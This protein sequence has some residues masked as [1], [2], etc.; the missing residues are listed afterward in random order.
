MFTISKNAEAK[1]L[2]LA[3]TLKEN[4][5]GYYALQFNFSQ[6]QEHNRS[7]YQIK[8]AIN[9]IYDL[10]KDVEGG[11][12]ICQDCDMFFLYKGTNKAL[13]EKTIFQLRYLFADDPLAYKPGELENELFC[14]VYDLEFHCHD[15]IQS[16]KQK[17]ANIAQRDQVLQPRGPQAQAGGGNVVSFTPAHLAKLEQQLSNMNMQHL[18]RQQSICAVL[19]NQTGVR[20]IFSEMYINIAHLKRLMNLEVD[21]LGHPGLFKYLTEI[22]DSHM[23]YLLKRQMQVYFRS[24]ISLNLN[25]ITIL[26]ENFAELNA[27]IPEKTRNSIIIEISVADVFADIAAF[28]TARNILQRNGYRVCLDG[29]NTL[30]FVQID[31]ESLGFDLA[32]LQWNADL[33][34]QLN[35]TENQRLLNAINKC[36]A[37]RVILCRCDTQYAIDYGRGLGI[38]LFQGRHLDQILNP[39]SKIQN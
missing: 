30:S 26:S 11:I 2:E 31:R 20:P 15:F 8:I 38:S 5:Q 9:V 27:M 36:G 33:E 39:A 1:L 21:V 17:V 10:F 3:V 6:L 28:M 16:A 34:A 23:I 4:P 25:V 24:P 18:L 19:K 13:I 7:D 22:L 29:L 35:S 12:F 32:K 14:S 37:N